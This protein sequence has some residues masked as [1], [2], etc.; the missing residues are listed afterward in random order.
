MK[1]IY[2]ANTIVYNT[3][4]IL[5]QSV[6]RQASG[7]FSD[8]HRAARG[9][10]PQSD[11]GRRVDRVL[12]PRPVG[13]EI[14]M[15]RRKRAARKR[16]FGQTGQRRDMHLLW[17]EPRPDRVECPEPAK[18][19]RIL[20]AGDGASQALKEMMMRVHEAGCHHAAAGGQDLAPTE[21][22][23]S[24]S[25]DHTLSDQDISATQLVTPVIHRQQNIRIANQI[26]RH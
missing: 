5:N 15:V 17:S 14:E 2:D 18:E 9:M 23:R 3:I 16:Q 1:L 22:V 8:A 13:K 10:K 7:A 12:K 4:F 11:L 21:Q 19:Q 25:G 20:T 6:R 26:F 24:D